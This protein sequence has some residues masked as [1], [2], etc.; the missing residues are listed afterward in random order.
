MV[1]AVTQREDVYGTYNETRNTLDVRWSQFFNRHNLTSISL[2]NNLLEVKRVLEVVKITSLILT[3]GNDV[4]KQQNNN[5]YSHERTQVE[6]FLLSYAM[7]N[8]LPVLGI[9]RGF[10]ML[11]LFLGGS[12]HKLPGHSGVQHDVNIVE[13]QFCNSKVLRVNS[14]HNFG[15]SG[16][17]LSIDML[18]IAF[19]ADGN[20]EAAVHKNKKWIG[21][22]WHPERNTLC[23]DGDVINFLFKN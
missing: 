12:V 6:K 10:Q 2:T 7:D 5:S 15:I 13:N 22:M 19:D 4:I 11:N 23:F 18:P 21:L 8:K 3:G 20:V 17:A 16:E 1:I 9:C 14:Y